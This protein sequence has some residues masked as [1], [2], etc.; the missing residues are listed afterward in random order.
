MK[1]GQLVKV[2]MAGGETALRRVVEV[3]G[4]V[5]YV[6]RAETYDAAFLEGITP[7]AVGFNRRWVQELSDGEKE[8][9]GRGGAKA[10]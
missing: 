6:C 7:L 8:T 1:A 2:Q 3:R 9:R 4:D 10:S 5:V